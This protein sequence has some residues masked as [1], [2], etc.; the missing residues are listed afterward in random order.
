LPQRGGGGIA[1]GDD[2]LSGNEVGTVTAPEREVASTVVCSV[3]AGL[4]GVSST[5][6]LLVTHAEQNKTLLMTRVS[7]FM[8]SMFF[9]DS[10]H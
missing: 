9:T 10:P 6:S 3:A 2:E 8:T 5:G 4:E 7:A 1:A